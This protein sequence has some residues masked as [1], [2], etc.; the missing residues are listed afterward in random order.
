MRKF[1]LIQVFLLMSGYVLAQSNVNGLEEM[2]QSRLQKTRTGMTIL[3][4]WALG[5]MLIS[6]ILASRSNGVEKHFHQMNAY[7]NIVNFGIAAMGYVNTLN[8]DVQSLTLAA[9]VSEQQLIEKVLLFNTGLDVA[10]VLGGFYMIE[11]SRRN[12]SQSQRLKGF[13]RSIVLQGAFLFAF[14][15]LF[16]L[17]MNQHGAEVMNLLSHVRL[18]PNSLGLSFMF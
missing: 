1:I 2:N 6:P 7:W 8:Q 3:G 16:Y 14:D 9:S 4:S 13:G 5:N 15:L 18:T 17:K 11:R 12:D 10:Y